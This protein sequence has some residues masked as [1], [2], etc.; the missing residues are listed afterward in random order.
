LSCGQYEV[1][2]PALLPP[3]YVAF[4]EEAG[5]PTEVLHNNLR[6]RYEQGETAVVEAMV[7]FAELARQARDALGA[8]RPD[9]FSRLVDRNFDL[10]RAICRLPS[11]HV[12]MVEVARKVGASAKFAGSGG[13]IVGVYESERMF[14]D[15]CRELHRISCRVIKPDIQ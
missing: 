8:G 5:E 7:E 4:S 10:R 12:Q 6:A 3:L 15:L 11:E 13:A 1:L 9:E 2:D 14:E